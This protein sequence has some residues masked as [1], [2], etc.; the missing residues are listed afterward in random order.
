MFFGHFSTLSYC[1]YVPSLLI[2]FWL[3]VLLTRCHNSWLSF[4]LVYRSSFETNKKNISCS[5]LYIEASLERLPN[6]QVIMVPHSSVALSW[7]FVGFLV[8]F[9]F[10]AFTF[11]F[12]LLLEIIWCIVCITSQLAMPLPLKHGFSL[13]ISFL[14]WFQI[15]SLSHNAF[16]YVLTF[17]SGISDKFHWSWIYLCIGVTLF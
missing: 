17:I 12:L 2:F 10:L 11:R 5:L 14:E 6:T 7:L 16:S 3:Y 9:C 13:N 4:F 15:E 8:C 1:C